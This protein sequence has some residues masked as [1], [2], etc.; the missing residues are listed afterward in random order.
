MDDESPLVWSEFVFCKCWPRP[1]TKLRNS[2]DFIEESN[3]LIEVKLGV[4]SRNQ[5]LGFERSFESSKENILA[6]GVRTERITGSP[7]SDAGQIDRFLIFELKSILKVDPTFVPLKHGE[8][9]G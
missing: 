7:E 9:H 5:I 8:K 3:A 2:C 1:L 6:I 4:L